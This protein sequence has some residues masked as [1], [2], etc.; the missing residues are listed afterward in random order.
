MKNSRTEPP[1]DK[2]DREIDKMKD[3]EKA[4]AARIDR[5]LE[6]GATATP[7]APHRQF[8]R[9]LRLGQRALRE[10]TASSHETLNEN[11]AARPRN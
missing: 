3:A 1:E 2:D 7:H 5:L 11:R 9:H 4:M 10:G 6:R 8:H